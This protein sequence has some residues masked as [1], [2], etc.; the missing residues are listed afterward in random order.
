MLPLTGTAGH[1]PGVQLWMLEA[2][3]LRDLVVHVLA[4][5]GRDAATAEALAGIGA[6]IRRMSAAAGYEELFPR[7]TG[8][9]TLSPKYEP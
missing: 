7:F 8:L 3:A 6:A 1:G 9:G 4:P 5:A 2:C